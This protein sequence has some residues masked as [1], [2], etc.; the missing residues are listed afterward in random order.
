MMAVSDTILLTFSVY[1]SHP[2]CLGSGI[3]SQTRGTR[4]QPASRCAAQ[5]YYIFRSPEPGEG[6]DKIKPIEKADEKLPR[7]FPVYFAYA[8]AV[9]EEKDFGDVQ[10][11]LKIVPRGSFAIQGELHRRSSG[12]AGYLVKLK[13]LTLL[14]HVYLTLS[15]ESRCTCHE[16]SCG[17]IKQWS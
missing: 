9:P 16:P 1:V 11:E 8:I 13:K 5:G 14:L 15:E 17:R 2:S 3:I 12:Y 10:A 7:D 4:H 6:D